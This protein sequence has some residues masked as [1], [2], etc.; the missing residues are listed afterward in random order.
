MKEGN[1]A[2]T[3]KAVKSIFERTKKAHRND[4]VE[5]EPSDNKKS[6]EPAHNPTDINKFRL[7]GNNH[8]WKNFPN[9]P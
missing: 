2:K 6:K 7:N 5:Q 1:K 9:N 3:L 4:E 8:L